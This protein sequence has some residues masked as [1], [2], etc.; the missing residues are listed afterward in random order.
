[1]TTLRTTFVQEP[2]AGSSE[3]ARVQSVSDQL[4]EHLSTPDALALMAAANSPGMSSA[5]V[6][7]AFQPFAT[8]LG[9][10][11]EAKGLF[12]ATRTGQSVPTTTWRSG[13][14]AS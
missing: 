1:M 12:G 10:T 5:G 9:F 8:E 6:Q 4:L 7:A 3:Y 13:A 11:N 14:P 2:V